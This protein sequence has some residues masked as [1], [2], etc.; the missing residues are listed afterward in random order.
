MLVIAVDNIIV[1]ILVYASKIGT[2]IRSD[3]RQ[4]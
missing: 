3:M 2:K 4:Q 1:N